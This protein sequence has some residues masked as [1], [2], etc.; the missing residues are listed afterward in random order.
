MDWKQPIPTG[1]D[2]AFGYDYKLLQL[3]KELIYR[4]SNASVSVRSGKSST[5]LR[6]G[7]ALFG[8]AKYAK[9]VCYDRQTV[10]RK[11]AKLRDMG[12]IS[13]ESVARGTLVTIANYD[14]LVSFKEQPPVAPPPDTDQKKLLSDEEKELDDFRHGRGRYAKGGK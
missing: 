7:Q 2:R 6:R 1:L 9:Y 4:S 10:Y 11:L 5:A 8:S 13:L 3:Y 12:L 14:S